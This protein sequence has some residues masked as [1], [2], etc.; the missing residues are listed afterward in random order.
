[1]RVVVISVTEVGQLF[2]VKRL[3]HI[4]GTEPGSPQ[5]SMLDHPC[6]S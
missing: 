4:N 2:G 3:T 1:M 5:W 6:N